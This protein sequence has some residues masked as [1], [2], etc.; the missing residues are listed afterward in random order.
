MSELGSSVDAPVGRESEL[1]AIIGLVDAGRGALVLLTGAPR[2]GKGRLLRG[3]RNRLEVRG[4]LVLPETLFTDDT[5]WLSI[6]RQSTPEA[7]GEQ[8][9]ADPIASSVAAGGL[10]LD[11]SADRS[12]TVVLIYGYH[13]DDAFHAWFR[14]TFAPALGHTSPPQVVVLAAYAADVEE[15]I[16][17]ASRVLDLGL[18]DVASV[19][20]W[21]RAL[22]S[23]LREPLGSEEIQDYARAAA[24]AP[25][26]LEALQSVLLR[27][28]ASP[29]GA[30]P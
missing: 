28:E 10:D 13:P 14:D 9:T 5:C 23:R 11:S 27:Y 21:L 4:Q 18:L 30:T 8:V 20:D 26:L 1:E 7:F 2:I 15:L 17:L 25:G 3:L 24:E 12:P 6:D 29:A 19:E 16:P 22:S